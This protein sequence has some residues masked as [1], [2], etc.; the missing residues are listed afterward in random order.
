MVCL[1]KAKRSSSE[2][3][4]DKSQE[5]SRVPG[6]PFINPGQKPLLLSKGGLGGLLRHRDKSKSK[7][8]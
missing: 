5:N 4:S 7:A 6:K 2:N 3:A 1:D 8:I